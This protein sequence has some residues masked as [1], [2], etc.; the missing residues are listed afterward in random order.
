[1]TALELKNKVA[2]FQ[3]QNDLGAQDT[4]MMI[5][6]FIAHN[7]D[8]GPELIKALTNIETKKFYSKE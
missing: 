6:D 3:M 2:L 1:M 4:M 7:I 5:L 8:A